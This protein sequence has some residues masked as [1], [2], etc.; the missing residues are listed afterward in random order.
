LVVS[1]VDFT[2]ILPLNTLK[3]SRPVWV[4]FSAF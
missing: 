4:A 1:G 3:G 2:H